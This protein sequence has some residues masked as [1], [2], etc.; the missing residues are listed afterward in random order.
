M[1]SV[2]TM[3]TVCGE[4][5]PSRSGSGL[6]TRTN[7]LARGAGAPHFEFGECRARQVVGHA[8]HEVEFR[9]AV[10]E[11]SARAG[12][13]RSAGHG[14]ACGARWRRCDR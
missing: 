8:L 13:A 14:G 1:S 10:I 6:N 4:A 2:M 11:V 3:M 7:E 12:P 5:N 9:D